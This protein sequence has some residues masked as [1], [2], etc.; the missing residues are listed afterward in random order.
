MAFNSFTPNTTIRSAAVNTNFSG[1]A[2]GSELPDKTTY[3]P[4]A[5]GPGNFTFVAWTYTDGTNNNFLF[6]KSLYTNVQNINII[7]NVRNVS[8]TL[9]EGRL[10]NVTDADAIDNSEISTAS[11]VNP[12]FVTSA[13]CK[14]DMPNAEKQYALQLQRDANTAF[15][16]RAW[17]RVTWK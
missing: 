7:Y 13:D 15:F 10:Y 9:A 6:D 14:A 8:S 4:I 5:V 12:T 3:I 17:L 16:I 1:I 2:D 11:A